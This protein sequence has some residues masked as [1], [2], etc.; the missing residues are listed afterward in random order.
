MK[1]KKLLLRYF[2]LLIILILGTSASAQVYLHDFG[3]ANTHPYPFNDAPVT[4]HPALSNSSWTNNTGNWLA[5][6][7]STGKGLGLNTAATGTGYFRLTF[8]V[9]TGSTLSVTSFNFWR[10][11]S[12]SAARNWAVTI[13]GTSVGTG[14]VTN[15][16]GAAIGTQTLA[17]PLTGLTGTV[18]VEIVV[19]NPPNGSG[20]FTID[21]FRLNGT[22]TTSCNAPSI[23]S[24]N[25]ASG[26]ANTVVTIEGSGFEAGTG[27]IAVQFNGVNAAGFTVVSNTIIKAVVP[28]GAA[29]GAITVTTDNC[30]ANA[31]VFAVLATDCP[32]TTPQTEIYISELYDQRTGSGGMIE[33]YNPT[34]NTINL[35]GY[36]LQRY[37]DITDTTPSSGYILNLTGTIGPESTYLIASSDPND[38][39]CASPAH[40]VTMGSGFNGNDKFELLKN[41]VVIDLVHVP[42]TGPG[43]TLIRQPDA[44]APATTYNQADWN[45]TQHDSSTSNTYCSDLG[46]HM[47]NPV[48][49]SATIT[50]HP[51]SQSICENGQAQFTVT[52]SNDAGF[53]YQWKMLMP[54][55]A[56]VNVVDDSNYSG[57][58]T[59]TLT[60]SQIP[61]N[62]T[63][64]QYYCLITSGSCTLISNAAQLTVAPIPVA[65][66]NVTVQ[67]TCAVPTGSFEVIPSVGENL[68]YSFNGG[69]FQAGT[70]FTGIAPG[71]YDLI[72]KTGANCTATIPVTIN[73]VPNAPAVATATLVQPTC[74]TATGSITIT[75][76]VGAGFTYSING[77]TF[78]SGT[79]FSNL[80]PDNYIITV[81]NAD[82]CTSTAP[83]VTINPAPNAPAV[84]TAT[85]VQPTC[86]TATGSI[87]ITAP[88]GAGF[89]YS[90]N[91]GTFQSGTTFSNLVPDNYIITVMNADG[92]TSTAPAVTINPAPNAPAVATATLVQPTCT[93][94]TGSITITAPTGAG[95]T[96]SINGGAFQSGTTFSNLTPDNYIITIMNADGC[97]STAPAVTINPAPN[98]PAVATATLVQPTCTTSTG[99]ITITAPTG[100]GFTYSINGG[101]FQSG[102]TFSNLVPDNYII[103]VMNA[104]GC[105]S[106]APAV[107][108]NPAPNAPA[109]ATATLVQPTCTTSTGSITITA[110]VGAGFTYSINGGTF[111]SSATFSNL[112]PDNYIITVMNADGCTSTAPA[113]TINPAPNAPAVATATLV[114]PT[115]TTSTGSITIIAPTGAGF[116]YSINGGAFQSGTTFSNLTPDNYIITVMNADGCT[117]TAPAVTINPAPNAPAIATATLVQPTCTTSTGSITI[118]APT[119]AGFT[120]SI[121]GGAFQSGTTF[122]NLTPDNYIITV[123]NADGCTS[124]AP[125]VTI[126]PAPNAPAV[127]TA[128]LVQPTCTTSTGSITITAPTGAG[129]TYSIN[130]GAFQNGTTFSNLTPDNYIITV[131]NAD[132]CTSTAAAV[133]INPAPNAP[134]VA[135]ATLVQ[136]T[137]TTSTGSITV[138]APVGAGFTYSI[139]GGAF[140][141]GITFSN[142]TPDNYIITVMSADGCTST[143]PAVTIL[144]NT[145]TIPQ[146]T[147]IEGCRET[148]LGRNYIL[149]AQPT[150][151]TFDV[152]TASFVWKNEQGSIISSGENMFNVTQYLTSVTNPAFPMDFT[153]TVTSAGGCENTFTFRVDGILCGIPKGISPNNDG[154][155]DRFDLTGMNVRKLA[156]FNRY[157]KEV[158]SRNNYS[159]EW[160]GQDSNEHELPTGTY[161]YMI[162]AGAE[163]QT[164]WVYVNREE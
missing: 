66:I 121:N 102:T 141:S 84:A 105:T 117:S 96:Y 59:P 5:L 163:Q 68:T 138:T 32:Q 127:A 111:Q 152:N 100:A 153:L 136:P 86:T 12:P 58:N 56:W 103:T 126:N 44:V 87:T 6:L 101:A 35:S 113:V 145:G 67:P 54:N 37:G 80:T 147:Q 50:A 3:D 31:S 36:T 13:N 116:T 151:N 97:T 139:N 39:I 42:F 63:L 130:G 142:L 119:G 33:L 122:S 143:A 112:T 45:N 72:V 34:N 76:P 9:A 43:Y 74:I 47:A 52:V 2:K 62:F 140:Q 77:G 99:S 98:A 129:F 49:P 91:G 21:D 15:T 120:Y 28:S 128:T 118:T 14:T 65:A 83:A 26:P 61:L 29:T 159:N 70:T 92:C 53:T 95:F 149:E 106:T 144:P 154:L 132:G 110:P 27:T 24:V 94:A 160:V 123:M 124:T 20:T 107:T 11:R 22:V 38:A 150:D 88:T 104:D 75:A 131:M 156:I 148:T 18:T 19:S 51:Q 146:I 108:I 161:F 60:I 82:G 23:T 79:T 78:Q 10:K 40:N 125:A 85:L 55:G 137:C 17:T 93:T 1:E 46:N 30:V 157:G 69:A 41:N 114:Q 158:Y 48:A 134:A 164:G 71:T 135:T 115:C 57:A 90:I 16:T 162:E 64:N 25:P 155:N 133:T 109:V 8:N 81:M 73:A 89:T 7:G 4:L